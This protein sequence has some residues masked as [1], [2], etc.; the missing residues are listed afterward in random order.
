[1]KQKPTKIEQIIQGSFVLN[2]EQVF[3]NN[4]PWL[5]LFLLVVLLIYVFT[6]VMSGIDS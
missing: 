4:S 3:L 6:S 2:L 1:M 5:L